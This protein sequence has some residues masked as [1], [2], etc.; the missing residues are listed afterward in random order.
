MCWL[1]R[2]SNSC[3]RRSQS[4]VTSLFSSH[5]SPHLNFSFVLSLPFFHGHSGHIIK[6]KIF[7]P[8]HERTANGDRRIKAPTEQVSKDARMHDASDVH[9]IM[10][11]SVT[12]LKVAEEGKGKRQ[13]IQKSELLCVWSRAI[14][15]YPVH[16]SILSRTSKALCGIR[17]RATYH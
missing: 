7:G 14:V 11:P 5:F 16:Y 12:R 2:V 15:L 13:T 17:C 6:M 4:L 1:L 8:R 9:I 10:R 3:D